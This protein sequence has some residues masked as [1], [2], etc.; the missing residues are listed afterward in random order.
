MNYD[1]AVAGGGPAGLSAAWAA[2]KSG[3]R[4]ALF[5]KSREIGYP[6]HTSG[7]SWID[8]LRA[9]DI[10]E[11][12][13]T[14][15]TQ[16]VLIGPKETA[17]F[18]YN[19]PLSCIVDVRGLYQYLAET[20]A[21]AGVQIF[22]NTTVAEVTASSDGR[23]D[24]MLIRTVEG[25]RT[26]RAP[27]LIDATGAARVLA[28]RL[29]VAGP[30][31]RYGVGAEYDLYAPQWPAGKVALL[32]GSEIAPKGYG[33]IF[34]HRNNRVRVGVGLIHPDTSQSAKHCLEGIISRFGDALGEVSCLEYHTGVI[35]STSVARTTVA[36]GLLL[37]GDAGVLISSLLGEGIRFAIDIG[38]M[39]GEVAAEAVRAGRRDAAF[40]RKYEHRW[41]SKYGRLFEIGA[42][43][44]Q[45]FAG[46]SDADWDD[47][48]RLVS[49]LEPE[50]VARLLKGDFDSAA[51]ARLLK[52]SANLAGKRM[53]AR[54][55]TLFKSA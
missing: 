29:G 53:S 28:R 8:E 19:S 21:C 27:I 34:A 23:P 3:V 2:A 13:M 24:G 26:V 40:L 33:W 39:A 36:D 20:A 4:V 17:V 49:E 50:L 47:R 11:Q 25:S 41:R 15:V 32:F 18:H 38:R 35:P 9:L 37:A 5:E 22:V 52:S 51:L 43:L 16:G 12:F 31:T 10:P 6:I 44:N 45:R 14:P 48:I 46:Y 7:G 1:V 30:L 42:R 55:R 54:L